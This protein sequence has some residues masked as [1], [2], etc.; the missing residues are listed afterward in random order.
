MA[1]HNKEE[2]ARRKKNEEKKSKIELSSS[3]QCVMKLFNVVRVLINEEVDDD[4]NDEDD[5]DVHVDVDF[6]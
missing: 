2:I 3:F 4:V 1:K 5:E 6:H